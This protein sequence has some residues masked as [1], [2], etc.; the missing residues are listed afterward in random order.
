[1]RNFSTSRWRAPAEWAAAAATGALLW[2]AMPPAPLGADAAWFG[3]VP[4][5]LAVR[6]A[7]PR[8]AFRLGLASGAVFWL[9]SLTWIWRLIENNGPWPLVVF[10]YAALAAYCAL[11]TA[12]FCL[13]VARVWQVVRLRENEALRLLAAAVAEPL[14]W[15][16][17][18]FLRCTLLTGFPWHAL[19]VSQYANL[20]MLQ[21]ASLG[22]VYAVS[23]LVVLVNGAVAG[24]AVRMV[25]M[26]SAP[27]GRR[28][29]GGAWRS[30]ETFVPLLILAVAWMWGLQRVRERAQAG[31][32][33]P[34]WRLAMIQPDAPCIF[35]RND[36]N[37]DLA[38]RTL[39]DLTRAASANRP[40]LVI[41]PETA[42][43]G[44]V[45]SDPSAMSLAGNG[46]VAA[47]APLLTGATETRAGPSGRPGDTVFYNSAWLFNAGGLPAGFY[48][49]QHLVPFGEFIP[50]DG[51]FPALQRLSPV[52]ISC[53]PG[54]S[55]SV[56]H[57]VGRPPPRGGPLTVSLEEPAARA[58]LAFSPLI[59][60][61]DTVSDLS[62][63]AVRAGARLLVNV[64]NDSWFRGSNEPEQHLA[65]AIFRCVETGVPM[66]RAAN[67]GVSAAIDG[68]GRRTLLTAA[69]GGTSGF[70]GH[71]DASL[72]VPENP[73]PTP[74]LR[75]GDWLLGRP[76]AI[77]LLLVLAAPLVRR[78]SERFHPE[79]NKHE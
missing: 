66:A 41:W 8:R 49:K 70:A 61:E 2:G 44:D 35:A 78:R 28:P 13:A 48:R 42:L 77:V 4:L 27:A 29:P 74:Y 46:A 15:V 54:R 51:V 12:L 57:V 40:D 30:F 71:L 34:V 7:A 55:S 9:L 14:L 16:G 33:A 19:G 21:A 65:Q 64:S 31:A 62:R 39:L 23:A 52:G 37:A 76:A 75:H 25:R 17:A 6:H 26:A 59:C 72:A 3:M 50:L 45:P 32:D 58:P 67:T 22:G 5:L 79:G 11:Y 38:R 53:T 10:G 1:M 73:P 69:D 20:V 36:E 56:L 63:R 60:F 18:E 68:I 47:G 43:L 24:L